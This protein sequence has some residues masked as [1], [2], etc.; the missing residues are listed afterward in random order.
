VDNPLQL[1]KALQMAVLFQAVLMLVHIAGRAWGESGILG[2]AALLGL[3]DVDVLTVSMA[4]GA[5]GV[6]S[7]E[8][9]ARAIAVGVLSNTTLK[10]VIAVVLGNARFRA[11]TGGTLALII[12]VAGT[13]LAWP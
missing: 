6:V 5:A 9:A 11:I 3:T 12:G 4:R 13:A 10:L 7:V 1:V 8:A 2:S